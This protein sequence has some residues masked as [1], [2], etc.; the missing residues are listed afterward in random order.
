M[1]GGAWPFL[2]GGVTC[3]VNSVNERDLYLLTSRTFPSLVRF[4][5][6]AL[7]LSGGSV[8]PGYVLPSG[9]VRPR[10]GWPFQTLGGR[11]RPTQGVP[12]NV[13]MTS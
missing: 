4:S 1:V 10:S 12:G 7:R 6:G 8:R 2:V 3:L 13:A 9:G 11:A 5:G